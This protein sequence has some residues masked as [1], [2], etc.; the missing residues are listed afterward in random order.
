MGSQS[1]MKYGCPAH[2]F[3][4]SP[5][6]EAVRVRGKRPLVLAGWRR[7]I[8]VIVKLDRSQNVSVYQILH[9]HKL[10]LHRHASA[11]QRE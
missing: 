8:S 9:V 7:T 10:D 2:R 1:E 4:S 3:V 6:R 11:S 5:V